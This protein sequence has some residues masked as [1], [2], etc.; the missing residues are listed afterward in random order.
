MRTI[1]TAAMTATTPSNTIGGPPSDPSVFNPEGNAS[2]E[3]GWASGAG[4]VRFDTV[5]TQ[6]WQIPTNQQ[7]LRVLATFA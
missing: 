4:I 1:P 3:L 2:G 6:Q 5:G 7:V